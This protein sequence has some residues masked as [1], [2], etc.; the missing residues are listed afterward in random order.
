MAQVV[1]NQVKLNNG[2]T[3]TP[4]QG[5]WYDGQQFWGGTLSQP[6]QI[7]AQSN[8]QGAG[9]AVSNEVIAQ[10]NPANVSYV[11]QQQKAAGVTPTAGMGTPGATP[12]GA[13]GYSMPTQPTIDLQATYDKAYNT[14]EI[15]SAQAEVNAA[16]QKILA[17]QKA[18]DEATAINNDNPFYSEATR[19]GK[20]NQ[21]NEKYNA[22][23]TTMQNEKN[24][25]AGKLAQLKSDAEIKINLAMKQYDINNQQY[26]DQLKQFNALLSAGALVN[27]APEDIAAYATAVGMPYAMIAG[28]V[29][30]QKKE[31]IKP[32]MITSTDDNG[33]VTATII[34][35]A[36][37]DVIKQTSLGTIAGGSSGTG[38]I[39]NKNVNSLKKDVANWMTLE[40]LAQ[41]Y[42]GIID[43]NTVVS[44]YNTFH[45][46][47]GDTWGTAKQN[48]QQL[49][50]LFGGT[51][52]VPLAQLPADDKANINKIKDGIKQ[53]LFTRED[54]AAQFPEYAPYF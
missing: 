26:Q 21:I 10:T 8:Q 44:V 5:G 30:Q 7:N 31:E 35:T 19:V 28:V 39:G 46:Q 3:I 50:E 4:Q 43:Q 2:Q 45:S 14:P 17:A 53:G 9:Q 49:N 12:S 25:A 16:D 40:Q 18:R 15:T 1:G 22:D 13:S 6:G 11:Q 27:A 34:D 52:A 37:G 47:K 51:K 38:G 20:I 36:T 24:L 29:A 54:A 33:N 23:L 41:K 42:V 48:Q 32:Q